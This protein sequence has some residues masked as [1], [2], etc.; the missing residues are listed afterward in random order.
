MGSHGTSGIEEMVIGS[1]TEKNS[2]PLESSSRDQKN[3]PN[4][5]STILFSSDFQRN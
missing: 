2:T 1:N 3:N 4:L 5:P